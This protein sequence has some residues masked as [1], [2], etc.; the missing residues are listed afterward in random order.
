MYVIVNEMSVLCKFV[1]LLEFYF[2]TLMAFVLHCTLFGV[3]FSFYWSNSALF[4]RTLLV[5]IK[6]WKN[7]QCYMQFLTSIVEWTYIVT[8]CACTVYVRCVPLS[9]WQSLPSVFCCWKSCV[10][11]EPR[12]VLKGKRSPVMFESREFGNCFIPQIRW[13]CFW[14]MIK[15]KVKNTTFYDEANGIVLMSIFHVFVENHLALLYILR[16]KFQNTLD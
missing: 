7:G 1:E 12:D 11:L 2:E 6:M 9:C 10:I 16:R 4:F 14:Q 15:L 8:E 5:L 13:K 3:F